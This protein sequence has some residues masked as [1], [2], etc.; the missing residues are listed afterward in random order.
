MI[1]PSGGFWPYGSSGGSGVSVYLLQRKRYAAAG[2]NNTASLD[3]VFSLSCRNGSTSSRIQNE[4]PWVPTTM[5]S[6]LMMRSL[7]D[8]AGML[9]RSDDQWSPSSNET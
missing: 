3:A 4:R 7:I 5:S 8:V 6:S 1:A 2:L 9:R